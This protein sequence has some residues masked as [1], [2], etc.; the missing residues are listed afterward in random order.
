MLVK[1]E[2]D[3]IEDQNLEGGGNSM[4]DKKDIN[5]EHCVKDAANSNDKQDTDGSKL[6][7]SKSDTDT[8]LQKK[9]KLENVVEKT[10]E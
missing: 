6:D 7:G 4:S 10:E 8:T 3:N 1:E 9:E 2:E 5:V